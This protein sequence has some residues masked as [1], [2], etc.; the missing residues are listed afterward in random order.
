MSV[1]LNKLSEQELDTA[2]L[3]LE[4]TITAIENF[5]RQKSLDFFYDSGFAKKRT[6]KVNL[7]IPDRR[8]E[9]LLRLN[10]IKFEML[11]AS[12]HLNK[13]EPA[14]L[15]LPAGHHVIFLYICLSAF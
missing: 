11:N 3:S 8:K 5:K 10:E 15:S 2:K 13:T 4:E 14:P 9:H 7:P 6:N 12:C 1:I